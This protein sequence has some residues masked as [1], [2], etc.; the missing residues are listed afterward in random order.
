MREV[1]ALQ[2]MHFNH[3]S[4]KVTTDSK[5]FTLTAETEQD[6]FASQSVLDQT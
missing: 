4:A 5:D 1:P 2:A 6:P 3:L